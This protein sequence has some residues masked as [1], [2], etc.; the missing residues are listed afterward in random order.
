V[1]DVSRLSLKSFYKWLA[2]AERY[3]L[4]ALLPKAGRAPQMPNVTQPHRRVNPSGYA[5]VSGEP[6][7]VQP[8]HVEDRVGRAFLHHYVGLT[9]R[10]LRN[11]F[12]EARPTVEA[13]A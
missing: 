8:P 9:R 2:R 11:R 3:G 7:A 12:V 6:D 4:E 5:R 1:R 13:I 10:S